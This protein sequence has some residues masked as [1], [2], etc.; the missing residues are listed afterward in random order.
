MSNWEAKLEFSRTH[1]F[2]CGGCAFWNERPEREWFGH[3][4]C[5]VELP[6][7]LRDA[8]KGDTLT[9]CLEGCAM[10]RKDVWGAK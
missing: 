9:S 1:D 5:G 10:W 2:M 4:N 6:P 7:M 3:G 8:A